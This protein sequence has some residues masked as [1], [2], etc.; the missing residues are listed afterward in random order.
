LCQT[1]PLG[2][3]YQPRLN[4]VASVYAFSSAVFDLCEPHLEAAGAAGVPLSLLD[5]IEVPPGA[6]KPAAWCP[7][8]G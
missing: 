2:P 8:P 7:G 1:Q 4:A 6:P 5:L 3:G